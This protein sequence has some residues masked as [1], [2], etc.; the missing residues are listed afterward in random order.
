MKYVYI[1]QNGKIFE[2]EDAGKKVME[3]NDH[4][5]ADPNKGIILVPEK[6]WGFAQ[7]GEYNS[8]MQNKKSSDDR[9]FDHFK[10]FNQYD[11]IKN[12]YFDNAIELGCG[13]FTNIRIIGNICSIDKVSLLDPLINEYLNHP[14]CRYDKENL[15]L[16]N[17]FF[18][19]CA[20]NGILFKIKKKCKIGKKIPI[21]VLLPIPI[22]KMLT[23]EKYDLCVIINVLEHCYDL[24][25]IFA[26]ILS[27][28]KPNGIL[29][30]HDKFYKS[31]DVFVES[32]FQFDIAHP[33]KP[34][35]E[36]IMNFLDNNFT[37]L[38]KR[39][40]NYNREWL[41]E[42]LSNEMIYFIG[43]KT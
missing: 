23:Q 34:N 26:N 39:F 27:I 21:N 41:G 5:Y 19:K 28:L 24:N 15:Y 9:N 29:I 11:I 38:Y 8:W 4:D 17:M 37:P 14:N 13:P 1:D 42:S 16:E 36:I 10:E 35:K 31:K 2:D 33:L 12:F 20:I 3:N 32:K 22:E 18:E 25:L 7:L 43:K 40:K 6:R 30:F